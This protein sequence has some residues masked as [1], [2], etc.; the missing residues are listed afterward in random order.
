[1]SSYN[2][3][4]VYGYPDVIRSSIGPER[5]H[6]IPF[7][8][9][10]VSF[11]D[12]SLLKKA[13]WKYLKDLG[14]SRPRFNRSFRKALKAQKEYRDKV[15]ETGKGIIERAKKKDRTIILLLTRP[16]QIDPLVNHGIPEMISSILDADVITEDAVPIEGSGDISNTQVLTQWENSNRI[17]H[18]VNWAVGQGNVEV[19]QLNSFGCGPD[20]V[21]YDE[22]IAMLS[23]HGKNHTLIRIDEMSSPGSVKLS[24]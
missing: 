6:G 24:D 9:P 18:A 15:L 20:A 8:T 16:Y 21:V 5:M 12:R 17:F 1:M 19:V 11:R 13:C 23:E 2:C 7:D 10:T 3:P 22:A 14:V 4:I